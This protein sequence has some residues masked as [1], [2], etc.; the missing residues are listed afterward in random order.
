MVNRYKRAWYGGVAVVLAL[1]AVIAL[2]DA[3]TAGSEEEKKGYLGVFMQ[4]L[5]KDV[6]EGLDIDVKNGVLISGVE[7]DS[8]A[9]EAGLKDGDVIVSFNG[10]KVD[11]PDDLRDL[12]RDTEP[13]EKVEIEVMR[14]GKSMTL[15][16]TV[17]EWPEDAEWFS[18]GDLHFDQGNVGRH[19]DKMVYA[20]APKPRLGVEVAELNDDLASYFK[21]KTGEG[22]LVL[23]V[24]E[25]SVAEGA[26]VKAG[27]VIVQ[28]GDEDVS[29]ADEL[30]ESVE[31]YEEGDEFAIQVVRKGKKKALTATMDE[32][33]N[34]FSWSGEPNVWKFKRH[35]PKMY[36]YHMRTPHV[37]LD[38]DDDVREE[39]EEMRKELKEMK[40]E[41]KELKK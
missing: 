11:D 12:V 15:T 7:E 40:K 39:L 2:A 6:R 35:M 17:G 19:L 32:V 28:V 36:K 26:G 5:D 24:K 13:G 22:V 3:V 34:A 23:K 30:R 25:K 9:D 20:F 14:E 1:A 10:K 37:E 8:P 21:T 27:D 38:V 29:S 33:E 18:L 4:E 16:L 41:L 31:D